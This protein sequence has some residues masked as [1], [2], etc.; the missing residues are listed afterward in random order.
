MRWLLDG[1][2]V[3]RRA[4]EL[5]GR[6]RESLQAAREAL[7][8]LL[9][10]AARVSGDHFTVVF[11]GAQGGGSMAGGAGVRVIFSSARETADQ[12]LGRLATPGIAVVSND[13]EVRHAAA[14]ARS[15]AITT[16][17]FLARLRRRGTPASSGE[18]EEDDIPPVTK[19][20]N[21]RRLPK[22]ARAAAR[23]LRRLDGTF[24][25]FP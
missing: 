3:I 10:T 6:E 15:I 5:A 23:A 25:K 16:D 13:R 21:P 8:R 20:G 17:E 24:K 19:K 7:C 12:V 11:D 2:N 18:S 4:P 22:K 1:Y 9:T 14:R